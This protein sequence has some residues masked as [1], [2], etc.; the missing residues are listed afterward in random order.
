MIKNI[1]QI[2]GLRLVLKSVIEKGKH[3]P[4][5]EEFINLCINYSYVYYRNSRYR[6][7]IKEKTGLCDKDL[8][9][10]F[11][12]DLFKEQNG[13]Y[14]QFNNFFKGTNNHLDELDEDE[15]KSKLLSLICT[16]TNQR[17]SELREEFGESYFKV[18]KAVDIALERNRNEF[19]KC[20]YRNEFYIHNSR[21]GKIYFNKSPMP[22]ESI[23]LEL[24][25][26]KYRTRG[27]PEVMRTLLNKIEEQEFYCKAIENK[28]LIQCISE[29]YK[30]RLKD[31]FVNY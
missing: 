14:Y 6:N 3:S 15:I 31:N 13:H 8:A 5:I 12:A 11:I 10:D 28:Q 24:H 27:I 20:I 25:G 18:K 21:A 19:K 29:F 26:S 17:I 4:A 23:L 30:Q 7:L 2:D 16:S 22:R 1:N 9:I